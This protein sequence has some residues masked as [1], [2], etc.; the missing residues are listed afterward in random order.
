MSETSPTRSIFSS[1]R[2]R[3]KFVGPVLAIDTKESN[4]DVF[5]VPTVPIAPTG[6]IMGRRSSEASDNIREMPVSM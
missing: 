4:G 3:S 6:N 5:L 2:N 1:P